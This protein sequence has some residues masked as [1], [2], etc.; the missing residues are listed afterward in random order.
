MECIFCKIVAG[1]IDSEK[2]HETEDLIV[3]QDVNPQAPT[4]LLIIPKKHF[5]TLLECN[6]KD[7]LSEMLCVASEVARKLGVAEKGFRV[8]VNTN[9]EGGQVVFHLH[10]H[11][12][13]GRPM[14]PKVG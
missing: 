2:I 11:L 1:E 12:L 4:H 10:M 14:G 5:P 8:A 7:L 13:A 9:A 6:D 3:I